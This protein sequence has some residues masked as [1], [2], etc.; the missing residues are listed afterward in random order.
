M[1]FTS[2]VL[3]SLGL[4]NGGVAAAAFKSV[5]KT[6]AVASEARECSLIGGKVLKDGGNAADAVSC[7]NLHFR[8]GN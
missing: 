6:G 4:F 7:V 2:T 8:H 5:G 3:L 1:L